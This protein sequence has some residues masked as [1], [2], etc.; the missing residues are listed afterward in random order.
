[1]EARLLAFQARY[2]AIAKPFKWTLTRQDLLK[3]LAKVPVPE[4][5][6]RPVA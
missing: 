1:V 2:E 5:A 6:E 4:H 3:V